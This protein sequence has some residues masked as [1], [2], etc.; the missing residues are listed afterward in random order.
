MSC[1]LVERLFIRILTNN[2][3]D[4]D[5]NYSKTPD[6]F[7]DLI[8]IVT[9][10]LI[11]LLTN[12]YFNYDLQNYPNY[13]LICENNYLSLV[14]FICLSFFIGWTLYSISHL[15]LRSVFLFII[16]IKRL[17]N[18]ETNILKDSFDILFGKEFSIIIYPKDFS[19]EKL[20]LYLEEKETLKN[21]YYRTV[22]AKASSAFLLG[23]F[24]VV[25]YFNF[26]YYLIILIII[27]TITNYKQ[28]SIMQKKEKAIYE[29]ISIVRK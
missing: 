15:W 1:Q 25:L 12:L 28:T 16:A 26:N 29:Q 27:L 19:R 18:K 11:L 4:M 17:K 20:L 14:I 10:S 6:F 24:F 22:H 7:T 9:G 5:I 23:V 3:N 8:A 2:Y 13:S 21:E